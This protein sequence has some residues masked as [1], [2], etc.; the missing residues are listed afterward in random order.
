[1]RTE[2]TTEYRRDRTNDIKATLAR[3]RAEIEARQRERER[4]DATF[5]CD[6][7]TGEYAPCAGVEPTENGPVVKAPWG[8]MIRCALALPTQCGPL[9]AWQAAREAQRQ[10][11]AARAWEVKGAA[12]GLPK[13]LRRYSFD[14]ADPTP[15]VDR[16]RLFL[17][18]GEAAAGRAL[19]LAGPT[20]VGKSVAAA[21]LVREWPYPQAWFV[22]VPGLVGAF[23]SPTRREAAL[24]RSKGASLLVLDEFGGEYLKEGGLGF[25]LIEELLAHR[26]AEELPTV[27][28]T[29]CTAEELRERL[30]D[31][32]LD[33]L[34]AGGT[35]YTVPGPS[36]RGAA[37]S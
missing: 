12:L 17:D 3:I 20:G 19:V 6:D 11:E 23:L 22:V 18:D 35:V 24:E 16:A 8:E 25:Y 7:H 1:M 26:E 37:R 13:K 10:E 30:S 32:I 36:R 15:P 2:S 33:R 4:F 27:L 31:R 21:C 5:E 34:Q 28:T 14:S 29:N 9:R